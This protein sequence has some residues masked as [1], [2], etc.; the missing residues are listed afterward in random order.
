MMLLALLLTAT[1]QV[2]VLS[3]APGAGR[4]E[5]RWQPLGQKAPA[6]VAASFPHLED[7]T[8]LGA[9]I[10]GTDR[11][12]ATASTVPSRDLS[13]SGTLFA[14]EPGKPARAL[15][16]QVAVSTRPVVS[17]QGRIFV[18][19]GVAG[20]DAD[21]PHGRVDSLEVDE[22][23]WATGTVRPVLKAQGFTL[24]LAGV[25]GAE[26]LVY[27]VDERGGAL[28]AVHIDAL[29]VRELVPSMTPL[30][31]DFTLDAAAH[32]LAFTQGDP[33]TRRWHV[34]RLDLQR[35]VLETV[36][37]DSASMALLPTFLGDALAVAQGEGLPLRAA[38][39]D[40]VLLDP[41][42]KG[43]PH[44]LAVSRSKVAV[45][46]DERPGDFPAPFAVALGSGSPVPLWVP[47]R[48]RLDLA[49]VRE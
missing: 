1:P 22:V 14:L 26:L 18:Q 39:G 32:T 23:D 27:R 47:A 2:A 8:A 48:A 12:V 35:S 21:G 15:V 40:A 36:G 29:G 7:A 3:T 37:Q 4:T 42:A 16:G 38:V 6:K 25:S 31:R 45:G 49:G 46:L 13:F 10:P 9:V 34:E 28:L 24:F 30:A 43:Y 5:L 44:V 17:A 19:R 33:A 41:R 20:T 11:V